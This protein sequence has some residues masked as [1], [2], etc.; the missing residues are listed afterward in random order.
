[1]SYRIHIPPSTHRQDIAKRGLDTI[2]ISFQI[3]QYRNALLLGSY[4]RFD[5]NCCIIL[6][7]W[8]LRELDKELA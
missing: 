6:I 1:M 8:E 3:E 2:A 4:E 7:N 5:L